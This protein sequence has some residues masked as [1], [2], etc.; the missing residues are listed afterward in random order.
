MTDSDAD[1]DELKDPEPP[2]GKRQR[3]LAA[4]AQLLHQQGVER[5][6]L[7][8]I[9]QLADV[10]L[11]NIY[12]YFKTKD[13][14]VEAVIEAVERDIQTQLASLNRHRSPKGRLKALV[15]NLTDQ[16]DLVARYGCPMGSLC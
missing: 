15:H 1:A 13:E 7:A 6:T 16:R 8:D 9:A 11:G 10:P 12:Y 4:A 3:L 14:L 2:L 5:T